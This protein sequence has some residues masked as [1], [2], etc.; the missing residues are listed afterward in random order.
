VANYVPHFD[1]ILTICV[2][3]GKN[4]VWLYCSLEPTALYGEKK[5]ELFKWDPFVKKKSLRLGLDQP[6]TLL[7]KP[8]FGRRRRHSC[9]CAN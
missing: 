7:F 1:F 5:A 3:A 9:P 8:R 4:F 2:A 6:I